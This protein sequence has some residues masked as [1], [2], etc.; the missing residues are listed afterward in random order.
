MCSKKRPGY[1]S[2]LPCYEMNNF[3]N[4]SDIDLICNEKS[5]RFSCNHFALN[6]RKDIIL[7]SVTPSLILAGNKDGRLQPSA[8]SNVGLFTWSEAGVR[9]DLKGDAAPGGATVLSW[10]KERVRAATDPGLSSITACALYA[11]DPGVIGAP[12]PTVPGDRASAPMTPISVS[13]P[14]T[15]ILDNA[16]CFFNWNIQNQECIPGGCVPPA[17]VATTRY[18]CQEA[19]P[20]PPLEEDPHWKNMEP[21]SQTGNDMNRQMFGIQFKSASL[22]KSL[23]RKVLNLLQPVILLFCAGLGGGFVLFRPVAAACRSCLADM[24][25][26]RTV[27]CTEGR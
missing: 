16:W 18:Q 8:E 27:T 4:L 6:Q 19:L 24:S 7:F 15:P 13:P 1:S 23:H 22:P 26:A 14:P 10:L 11:G 20:Y 5:L 25:P 9:K 17:Y 12:G 2:K 3:L 21:G